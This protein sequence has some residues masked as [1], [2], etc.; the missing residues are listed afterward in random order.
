M[1]KKTTIQDIAIYVG[2]GT[3]TVSRVINNHPNVSEKTRTKVLDAMNKL[4]YRPSFAAQ[5]LR[6]QHSK[7]IG[8]LTDQVATTPYAVDIIRGAQDVAW[9]HDKVLI[10]MNTGLDLSNSQSAVDALLDREVEGIIYAAMWHHAVEPPINI[11][12]VPVVL[13]NCFAKNHTLP[14]AIPD[15]IS[16][17]YT[18]IEYL[19][20]KG[21]Q[22]IAFINLQENIPAGVG[23]LEGYTRALADADID[24]DR[25]L[26]RGG[27]NNISETGYIET[28]IL[29][30][31]PDPPTAIFVG[32]DNIAVGVYDALKEL[33]LDIP[34]DVAVI[35][36]DNQELITT[37]LR[38][39]LTT[40][41]LPHY[42][43]GMWALNYLVNDH[44]TDNGHTV[45]KIHCPIVERSST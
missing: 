16:G 44:A 40:I 23:R 26:V 42:E 4:G 15:E 32:S 29:M 7:V 24:F 45:E 35:G 2:V 14:C 38:P 39:S 30:K 5:S 43:M 41:Q 10:V 18:A 28:H 17:G 6:K 12:E 1:P 22:R 11:Q 31:L 25:A 34:G 33:G 8:F 27:Y 3:G 36:F 20:N 9:E 21:H 37:S 13:A 19:I